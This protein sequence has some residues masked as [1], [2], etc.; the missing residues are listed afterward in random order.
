[1]TLQAELEQVLTKRIM[2]EGD[3]G[4][5]H[6][7]YLIEPG[8]MIILQAIL[9]AVSKHLPEKKTIEFAGTNPFGAI[10]KDDNSKI[11]A[12]RNS[13]ISEMEQMLGDKL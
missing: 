11:N 8:R 13:A 7:G 9:A 2:V 6:S 10:Y 4:I 5:C 3:N 1:M 12:G